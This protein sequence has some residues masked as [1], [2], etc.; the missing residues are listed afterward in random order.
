MGL[1]QDK[2]AAISV[3]TQR[4]TLS[5]KWDYYHDIKHVYLVPCHTTRCQYKCIKCPT[6]EEYRSCL[7]KLA[8]VND[9][10]EHPLGRCCRSAKSLSTRMTWES[11]L[12]ISKNVAFPLIICW[13][14][15]GSTRTHR[16]QLA[17]LRTQIFYYIHSMVTS[18]YTAWSYWTY[19]GRKFPQMPATVPQIV[20]DLTSVK[21]EL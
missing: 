11:L 20:Y 4:N 6:R 14:S 7:L 9:L 2:S 1:H 13:H 16:L 18:N 21:T 10:R 3:L 19:N 17:E 5:A 15:T 12:Q 8:K